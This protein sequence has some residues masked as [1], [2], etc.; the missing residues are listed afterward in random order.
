MN[1]FEPLFWMGC[2]LV[3]I[4][5]IKTDN[6]RLWLW[7]GLIAGIGLENKYGMGF[8]GAGIVLGLLL[9]E[10][11]RMF[12]KPWI[13][14]G[15]LIAM[16]CAIPYALWQGSHGWYFLSYAGTYA[17]RTSHSSPALVRNITTEMRLGKSSPASD[18][19]SQCRR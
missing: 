18:S 15:A 5:I 17:G 3:L 2:A 14:L 16:L 9:T 11:R 4:R 7:F 8:F 13:W 6:Q 19:T 1:A 12:L 10:H